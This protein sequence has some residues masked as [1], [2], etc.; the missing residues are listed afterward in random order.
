MK[1]KELLAHITLLD[2]TDKQVYEP[3]IHNLIKEGNELIPFLEKQ[4][5]LSNNELVQERIENIISEIQFNDI[6]KEFYNWVISGGTDIIQGAYIIAK[7]NYPNLDI[8][9]INDKVQ[10]LYNN[11]W[12]EIHDNLTALEK[13]RV[14]NHIL[15]NTHK[16]RSKL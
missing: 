8:E 14:I 5:E 7:Q 4:W 13:V 3:V 2:D 9:D 1:E 16:Y 10:Q 6:K 12:L 15:F 11:T